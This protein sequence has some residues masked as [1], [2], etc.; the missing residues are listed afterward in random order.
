MK[1]RFY[2]VRVFSSSYE[3]SE[4]LERIVSGSTESGAA[5]RR[6]LE[7]YLESVRGHFTDYEQLTV[8]DLDSKIVASSGA[9]DG[10][11]IEK[12]WLTRITA[13]NKVVGSVGREAEFD[14]LA[15]ALAAAQTGQGSAWLVGGE[16][17]V[18]KTRLI[19]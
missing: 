4:N 16:S 12:S 5:T 10:F 9:G 7:T 6:R 15:K 8:F 2:D 18:G 14:Q 13:D 19:D 17:G 11:V 3:V 1:E